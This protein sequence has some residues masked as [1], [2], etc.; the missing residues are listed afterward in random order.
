MMRNHK[1]A[2]SIADLGLGRF[3]TLLQ[4][5]MQERGGNYLEIGMFCPSSRMC[6][7]GV[8]NKELKLSDR[9]WTCKSCGSINDMDGLAANNILKFAL[10]PKNKSGQ[11]LSDEPMETLALVRSV[12]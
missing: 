11:V 6:G 5:K 8:I 10:N 1:L 9:I 2:Q 4:Y 7:C 3:Y 12:K